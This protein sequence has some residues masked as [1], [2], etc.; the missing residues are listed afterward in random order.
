LRVHWSSFQLTHRQSDDRLADRRRRLVERLAALVAVDDSSH[1][2]RLHLAL[3]PL[4]LADAASKRRCRLRALV[5]RP[6]MAARTT[7]YR[8]T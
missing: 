5:M 7:S 1:A 3:Q 4:D 2:R 8:C 6:S